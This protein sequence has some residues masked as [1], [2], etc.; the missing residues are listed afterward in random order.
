LAWRLTIGYGGHRRDGVGARASSLWGQ[1]ASRLRLFD[2]KMPV[3]PT[4]RTAAP[5]SLMRQRCL[6]EAFEERVRLVRFTLKFGMI[7]AGEEIGM[8][9]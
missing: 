4:A 7:L 5:L 9:A 1:Q 2:S 6:N 8:I 3:V